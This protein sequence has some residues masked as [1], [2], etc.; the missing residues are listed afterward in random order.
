[1]KSRIIT[2]REQAKFFRYRIVIYI[3][4]YC[5]KPNYE[6][7]MRQAVTT[8]DSPK[9]AVVLTGHDKNRLKTGSYHIGMAILFSIRSNS[10]RKHITS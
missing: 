10:V 1:M 6:E 7:S 2:V 9:A 4:L 3:T 5:T 8:L